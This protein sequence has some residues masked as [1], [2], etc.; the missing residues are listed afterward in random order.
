MNAGLYAAQGDFVNAG[1][2]LAGMIPVGGQAVTGGRVV[3]K[4]RT[5]IAEQVGKQT[6]KQVGE[7]VAQQGVKK[8]EK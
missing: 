3:Y 7:E 6:T 4:A 8:P 5:G 1:I 2:S